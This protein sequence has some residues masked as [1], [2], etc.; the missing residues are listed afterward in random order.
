MGSPGDDEAYLRRLGDR[1]RLCRL[2]LRMS[3]QDLAAAAGLSRVFVSAI[4]RGKHG[5]NVLALR[6]LADA[7]G[8][9]LGDLVCEE[10]A[11][12]RPPSSE[13]NEHR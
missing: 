13:R 7:L 3:Q 1:L 2:A 12:H 10:G 8:I 6:H 9:R 5:A 11:V 4:E